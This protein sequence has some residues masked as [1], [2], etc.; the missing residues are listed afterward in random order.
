MSV[1]TDIPE[2]DN[3]GAGKKV[4]T[5][6]KPHTIS[7]V[8]VNALGVNINK[9]KGKSDEDFLDTNKGKELMSK[10]EKAK[11][12]DAEKD[13][14]EAEEVVEKDQDLVDESEET[15]TEEVVEEV[16][17]ELDQ[18]SGEP[19]SEEVVESESEELTVEVESESVEVEATKGVEVESVE[20][21]SKAEPVEVAKSAETVIEPETEAVEVEV[22]KSYTS[23]EVITAQKDAL[24]TIHSLVKKIMKDLPD[25]E[26]WQ[27]TDVVSNAM[28]KVEDAVYSANSSLVEDI[29]E[30]VHAE[31]SSRVNKAK[32][33]KV[34]EES[35]LEE[36]VKALKETDPV[37]AEMLIDQMEEN[38][39][40]KAKA[41]EIEKENKQ[42]LREKALEKGAIDYKRIATEDN[43]TENIVD[44]MASIEQLDESA[45][46]VIKKALDTAS[47]I[48]MGGE[49]FGDIG[50]SEQA[51]FLS[52][53]EY[54]E[55][56]A[57]SL[58]DSDGGE[59]SA[60]RASVR[61]TEEFI[62]LYR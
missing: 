35:T 28:W 22:A 19:E 27:V 20:V 24:T 59:L 7:I 34:S 13:K 3:Q 48:T 36:K 8:G 23:E 45:H 44:A 15:T 55:T 39:A 21:E 26:I 53:K 4:L 57:K 32:A 52:E 11:S 16:V 33:L 62:A 31:V 51:K 14:P 43:T 42:I 38:K 12:L 2:I 25:A 37:M 9:V 10:I 18:K 29:Y 60:A 6:Y 41:L 49:L 47:T 46:K 58:V 30:E 56:K 61:Q 17:E 1:D 50:T 54:V 5:E 40:N